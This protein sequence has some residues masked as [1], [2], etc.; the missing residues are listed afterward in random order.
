M[1]KTQKR[2]NPHD[3]QPGAVC[4]SSLKFERFIHLT[5]DKK[6]L[7]RLER[8]NKSQGQPLAFIFNRFRLISDQMCQDKRLIE[9]LP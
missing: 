4:K 8:A 9:F 2:T 7:T 3:F 5:R 6:D 1:L